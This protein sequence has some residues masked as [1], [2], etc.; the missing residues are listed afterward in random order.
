[1][2]A[3]AVI[4]I[5]GGLIVGMS[6]TNIGSSVQYGLG[7]TTSVALVMLFALP[8]FLLLADTGF[9][10]EI[11]RKVL[12]H[13]RITPPLLICLTLIISW[14]VGLDASITSQYIIVMP[15]LYP[16]YKKFKISPIILMFFTTMGIVMDFDLPWTARTLRAVSLVPK[17]QNGPTALFGKILPVQVVFFILLLVIAYMVGLYVQKKQHIVVAKTTKERIAL[18]NEVKTIRN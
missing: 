3:F 17:V 14:I 5:I 10:N 9:F 8:Y 1:M 2:F 13:V 6:P 15:L 4:P 12:R 7:L 18:A 11:V 16:F